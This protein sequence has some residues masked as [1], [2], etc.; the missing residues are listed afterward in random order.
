M[1]TLRTIWLSKLAIIHEIRFSYGQGEGKPGPVDDWENQE[2]GANPNQTPE[3][4]LKD[5]MSFGSSFDVD[6]WV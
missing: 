5:E 3:V 6:E 4:Q 2:Q 1:D